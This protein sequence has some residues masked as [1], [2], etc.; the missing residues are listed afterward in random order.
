MQKSVEFFNWFSNIG[1]QLS[2]FDYNISTDSDNCPKL[3][4][5]NLKRNPKEIKR[6][7]NHKFQNTNQF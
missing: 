3:K 1:G 5:S 4:K 2:N 7:F 6:K